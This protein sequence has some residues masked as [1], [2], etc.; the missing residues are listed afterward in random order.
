MKILIADNNS[1]YSYIAIDDLLSA[2]LPTCGEALIINVADLWAGEHDV[3]GINNYSR[4][5]RTMIAVERE[6]RAYQE[7]VLREA[8]DAVSKAVDHLRLHLPGW[9]ICS[10]VLRGK[11]SSVLLKKAGEWAPDLFVLGSQERSAIGRFFL[12]S[13]SKTI[14]EGVKCSVRVVRRCCE[15]DI[16][17]PLRI[18]VGASSPAELKCVVQALD[19]R[20]LTPGTEVRLIMAEDE[21][22]M[23]TVAAASLY[24][25]KMRAADLN[26]SVEINQGSLELT[27]VNAAN[28]W[29]ADAIFVAASGAADNSGLSEL[30]SSLITDANCTIEVV[31]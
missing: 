10:D 17:V 7:S 21:G 24:A 9:N 1:I 5:S 30:S 18:I 3:S 15:R 22:S 28:Q 20:Q 4:F 19:D 29:G 26:T 8:E 31:R 14:A 13:M 16:A 6:T 11:P 23:V 2:A 27:L 25:D 12:G